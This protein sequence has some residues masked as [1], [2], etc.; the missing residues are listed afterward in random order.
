MEKEDFINYIVGNENSE[1]VATELLD[2][3]VERLEKGDFLTPHNYF[4]RKLYTNGRIK[5]GEVAEK[6]QAQKSFFYA[7]ALGYIQRA[8]GPMPE[9][10]SEE[11][12]KGVRI[13]HNLE[14]KIRIPYLRKPRS[15]VP[16]ETHFR[17]PEPQ[18]PDE[19]L[20]R[21]LI[22][23][24][25]R[26]ENKPDGYLWESSIETDL[27]LDYITVNDVLSE[28]GKQDKLKIRE[29]GPHRKI[30]LL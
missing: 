16:D 10:N 8:D 25:T 28:L 2:K 15:Q 7:L 3:E 24:H 19:T 13:L 21:V 17:R 27:G 6:Y 4:L 18:V 14:E 26:L 1:F 11:E 29:E 30:Q 22:Y 20:S 23:V 12:Q 5:L 9:K